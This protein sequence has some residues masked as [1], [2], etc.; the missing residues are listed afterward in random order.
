M[1][2]RVARVEEYILHRLR[3]SRFHPLFNL[4]IRGVTLFR[5][6]DVS[7]AM[8]LAGTGR[9]GTTW[10][11]EILCAAPGVHMIYEPFYAATSP[12]IWE[13]GLDSGIY[14]APDAHAPRQYE[15]IHDLLSGK[16]IKSNHLN[17]YRGIS[18]LIG[19]R[20]FLVKCIHGNRLLPWIEHHFDIPT[21]LVIRHP[22][23]VIASQMKYSNGWGDDLRHRVESGSIR[24]KMR[25]GEW[26]YMPGSLFEELDD[27]LG[28]L[29]DRIQTFE[30]FLTFKWIGDVLVPSRTLSPNRYV[31]TYEKFV[32]DGRS[33][34]ERLFAHVGESVPD[35]AYERLEKPS[36]T[37]QEYS[38]IAKGKN[39]LTT[40]RRHLSEKQIDQIL[41]MVHD[42]GIDIY[43]DSLVP[44]V[45]RLKILFS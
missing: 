23:A 18:G 28:G 42:A 17:D 40:W 34:I 33:E 9:S 15:Y 44:D 24:E 41:A 27:R 2:D 3:Y 38:N 39:P 22:C 43:D 13:H 10:I 5:E 8:L 7:D 37:T 32:T 36:R 30:Q 6:Y 12:E 19:A 31:T 35:S 26:P 45:D 11:A 21:V 25:S 4:L 14:L 16:K 29:A 20:R 1:L